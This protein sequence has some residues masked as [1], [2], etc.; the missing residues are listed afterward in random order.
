MIHVVWKS[1]I[2]WGCACV[3]A[4]L[5]PTLC[6]P[7]D[8]SPPGSSVHGVSQARILQWFA[9][10]FSRGSSW[11]RNR[12]CVSCGSSTGNWIWLLHYLGSSICW[13]YK[14]RFKWSETCH[15]LVFG[16]L[17]FFN[18]KTKP[19]YLNYFHSL[20]LNGKMDKQV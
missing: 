10:F 2:H 6:N 18:L 17:T 15:D 12:N 13:D 5:C 20:F 3:C 9:I 1:P 11:L 8:Y 7:M 16:I 4:Q 19:Y 14:L